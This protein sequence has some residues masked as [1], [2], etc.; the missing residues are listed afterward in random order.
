MSD[1]FHKLASSGSIYRKIFMTITSYLW[2]IS[3]TSIINYLH[4]SHNHT[5]VT[6]RTPS[7]LARLQGIFLQRKPYMI[8]LTYMARHMPEGTH[9]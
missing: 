2:D 9:L 4:I 6:S 8:E 1:H 7:M 3:N 5:Y